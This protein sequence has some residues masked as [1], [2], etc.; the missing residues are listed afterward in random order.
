MLLVSRMLAAV[1]SPCRMSR[2]CR[3]AMAPATSSAVSRMAPRSAEPSLVPRRRKEPL[4]EGHQLDW[5]HLSGHSRGWQCHRVPWLQISAAAV[6][7]RGEFCPAVDSCNACCGATWWQNKLQTGGQQL[8]ACNSNPRLQG[9]DLS[10][11][12][13]RLPLL[14]NSRTIH[15]SRTF[16]SVPP[17]E[18][19]SSGESCM[20][21]AKAKG[22]GKG[23]PA[24]FLCYCQRDELCAEIVKELYISGSFRCGA[25][26]L[27]LEER[28]GALLAQTMQSD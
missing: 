9:T 3:W 10:M 5:A 20:R 17:E 1:R 19:L 25:K 16:R 28:Q 13:C 7:S 8:Q 14:Q 26:D 6:A 2:E 22:P 21:G 23:C 24:A 18:A 11:A 27:P 4:Q 15:V 12:S